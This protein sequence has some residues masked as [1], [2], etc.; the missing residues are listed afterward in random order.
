[1]AS[2]D[3]DVQIAGITIQP[4]EI[5]SSSFSS[6]GKLMLILMSYFSGT[7]GSFLCFRMPVSSGTL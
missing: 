3:G 5:H 4:A 7:L 6:Q 1:M 2:C